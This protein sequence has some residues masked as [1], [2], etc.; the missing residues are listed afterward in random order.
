MLQKIHLI[1]QVIY[2]LICPNNSH[3]PTFLWI[4]ANSNEIYGMM[5]MEKRRNILKIKGGKINRETALD[6]NRL[7]FPVY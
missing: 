6:K 1:N 3:L 5:K 4:K 7:N 2:N